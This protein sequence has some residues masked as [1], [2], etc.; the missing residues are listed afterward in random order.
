MLYMWFIYDSMYYSKNVEKCFEAAG[1]DK[2][3]QRRKEKLWSQ[4]E[5][6]LKFKREINNG[7]RLLNS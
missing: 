2:V 5:K 3:L 1:F 6:N 4:E 7:D